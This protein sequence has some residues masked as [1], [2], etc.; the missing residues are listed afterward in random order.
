VHTA[1]KN[2][3]F[4]LLHRV[5]NVTRKVTWL[6]RQNTCLTWQTVKEPRRFLSHRASQ[7][8]PGSSRDSIPGN[9]EKY[10]AQRRTVWTTQFGVFMGNLKLLTPLSVHISIL[11]NITFHDF[12]PAC[13]AFSGRAYDLPYIQQT[14]C[15]P[16]SSVSQ[17][18]LHQQSFLLPMLHKRIRCT[19]LWVTNSLRKEQNFPQ[20]NRE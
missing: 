15:P 18:K 9:K 11:P 8:I 1:D 19:L 10:S 7:H 13:K 16:V 6:V 20:K 3:I 5:R 2:L 12:L 14:P 17:C 4:T